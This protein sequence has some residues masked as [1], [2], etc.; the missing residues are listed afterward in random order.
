MLLLVRVR[1]K[2]LLPEIV[3]A[4][5]MT[6]HKRSTERPKGLRGMRPRAL[7]LS[8][9]SRSH[10][11]STR[12]AGDRTHTRITPLWVLRYPSSFRSGCTA[13]KWGVVTCALGGAVPPIE[14]S[15]GKRLLRRGHVSPPGRGQRGRNTFCHATEF[16]GA[17]AV[18]TA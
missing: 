10:P 18:S 17:P 16:L 4:S 7:P 12:P 6:S 14:R 1:C 11:P 8:W 13:K 2:G 15:I 3:H 5:R 9:A